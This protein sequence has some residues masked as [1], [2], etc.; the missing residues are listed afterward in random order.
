[1]NTPLSLETLLGE[2]PDDAEVWA[3]RDEST[4][5]WLFVP[6]NRYPGRRPIASGQIPG[7]D[8]FVVH[9]PREVYEWL[10]D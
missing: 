5:E 1:M 6:D 3:L 2:F 10:H 8:A 9:S 4:G 7:I